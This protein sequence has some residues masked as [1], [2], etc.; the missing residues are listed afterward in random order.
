MSHNFAHLNIIWGQDGPNDRDGDEHFTKMQVGKS[1][2]VEVR[3]HF[4]LREP[5]SVKTLGHFSSK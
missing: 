2:Y 5:T 4:P 3:S 1:C